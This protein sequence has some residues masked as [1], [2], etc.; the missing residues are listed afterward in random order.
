M[1]AQH[2]S[3][4]KVKITNSMEINILTNPN[5]NTQAKEWCTN[6]NNTHK[7]WDPA[8]NL[9][10][11]TKTPTAP[12]IWA[13]KTTIS[14]IK[15]TLLAATCLKAPI[16]APIQ[17][18]PPLPRWQLTCPK[19]PM[20]KTLKRLLSILPT[21]SFQRKEKKLSKNSARKERASLDLQSICGTPLAH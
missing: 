9:M 7:I 16:W 2:F 8:L 20:T 3:E 11:Y 10:R 21:W 4:L 12:T 6:S 14:T 17:E 18:L 5:H 1:P 13:D 15:A 19:K